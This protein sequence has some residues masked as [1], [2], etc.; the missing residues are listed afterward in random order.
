VGSR[1]A[2][3]EPRRRMANFVRELLTLLPQV[4]CW[5]ISEHGRTLPTGEAAAAVGGGPGLGLR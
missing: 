4:S 1:F 2:R 5:A 3:V